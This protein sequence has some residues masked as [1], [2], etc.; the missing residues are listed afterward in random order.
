MGVSRAAPDVS[1]L[2]YGSIGRQSQAALHVR[3]A[4]ATGDGTANGET[5]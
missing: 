5:G 3:D 2:L 4:G 1:F